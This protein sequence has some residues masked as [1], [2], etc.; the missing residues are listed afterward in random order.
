MPFLPATMLPYHHS[1]R[2]RTATYHYYRRG[3]FRARIRAAWNS[4]EFAAEYAAIHA[5][6]EGAAAPRKPPPGD[7]TLGALIVA[8]RAS[9]EWRGLA[10]A[11]RKDYAK[12]L[13]LLE[14]GPG[15]TGKVAGIERKHVRLLRDKAASET[16]AE[17]EVTT[18]PTRGNKLLTA[19]SI[20]LSYAIELG[21]R[22]D[23]P[24]R[25]F[26]KLPTG[27]GG[28]RAWTDAEVAAFRSWAEREATTGRPFWRRAVLLALYTGQRGQDQVAMTRTHYDGSAIS[29][30]QIKTDQRV[31]VPAHRELRAELARDEAHHLLTRNGEAWPLNAFQKAAGVAIRAAGLSGVVWHGLRPTAATRLAEAGA[32]EREIMA[33]TGHKTAQ[34]VQHYTRSASRKAMAASAIARLPGT[35][36]EGGSG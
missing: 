3:K 14:Q 25:R 19:L 9:P 11:T 21:W 15:V 2:S 29:L 5:R 36:G 16:D 33:V 26:P 30:A 18:I 34:M 8:Y 17:G 20:L 13:A 35:E 23:N 28:Y 4:P 10:A 27:G 6:Y 32:S 7:R 1:Y 24:A 12:G 22:Q 31:W